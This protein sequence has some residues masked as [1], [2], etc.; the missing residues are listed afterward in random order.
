MNVKKT[1]KFKENRPENYHV[2]DKGLFR[3]RDLSAAEEQ[4]MRLIHLGILDEREGFDM[5]MTAA[6]R[7][8]RHTS[9][10]V[11]RLWAMYENERQRV[12]V[13]QALGD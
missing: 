4:F 7:A 10:T 6:T 5:P 12:C 11:M 9:A 3:G 2:S 13:L 8:M 1:K